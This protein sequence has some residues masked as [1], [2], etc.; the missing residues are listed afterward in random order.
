MKQQYET[1]P[2]TVEAV[3][4]SIENIED[5]KDFIGK[6]GQRIEHYNNEQDF[7]NGS[8]IKGLHIENKIGGFVALLGDYIFR[9]ATGKFVSMSECDFLKFYRKIDYGKSG[10]L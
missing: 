5:V 6:K 7:V 8:P 9:D 1:I 4:L 10:S 3:Q 2:L